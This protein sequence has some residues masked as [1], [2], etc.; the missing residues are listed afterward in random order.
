MLDYV[1]HQLE[2]NVTW[3]QRRKKKPLILRNLRLKDTAV[4]TSL[5]CEYSKEKKVYYNVLSLNG[6]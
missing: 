3:I 6:S 4:E 1:S 5:V 2:S